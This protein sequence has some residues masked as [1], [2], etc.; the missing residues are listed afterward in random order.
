MFSNTESG[1]N[2]FKIVGGEFG[3]DTN[4][5]MFTFSTHSSSVRN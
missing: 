1:A 2:H 5:T 4:S 3:I